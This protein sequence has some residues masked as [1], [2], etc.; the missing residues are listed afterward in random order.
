MPGVDH[1]SLVEYF[2]QVLGVRSVLEEIPFFVSSAG[3]GAYFDVAVRQKSSL[4]AASSLGKGSR[5]LDTLRS[6]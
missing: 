5:V 4:Y 3:D 6:R 1:G 2:L